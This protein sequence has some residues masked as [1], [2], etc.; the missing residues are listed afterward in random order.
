M[1]SHKTWSPRRR[2]L[3]RQLEFC[4][5]ALLHIIIT[6]YLRH[7]YVLRKWSF[8]IACHSQK[9]N[10]TIWSLSESFHIFEITHPYRIHTQ[11]PHLKPFNVYYKAKFTHDMTSRNT[12]ESLTC[13]WNETKR[14]YSVASR[15]NLFRYNRKKDKKKRSEPQG[16]IWS[17]V[18]QANT[19]ALLLYITASKKTF[20]NTENV[21]LLNP[22]KWI[23]LLHA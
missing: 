17:A 6:N 1:L 5:F 16:D 20:Q 22:W 13:L 15:Y 14:I 21:F 18:L 19:F 2:S 8:R 3:E 23:I 12:W 11:M 10:S 4:E 7:T 9:S